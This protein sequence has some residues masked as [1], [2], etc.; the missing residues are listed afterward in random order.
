MN[1]WPTPSDAG[2]NG[3]A[4]WLPAFWHAMTR[5]GEAQILLP[6]FAA[7]VAW[8]VFLSRARPEVGSGSIGRV[9]PVG[10]V[11]RPARQVAWR[12]TLWLIAGTL[13]TT[14][15][16]V[17]FIGY[18]LGSAA[19]DFTGFSG[20][21]M[22]ATAVLPVLAAIVGGRV[23]AA[24]GLVVALTVMVSRVE[25]QVHSWSEVI[26]GALIGLSI[27]AAAL[28]PMLGSRV[29]TRAPWWLPLL[30]AAWLTVLPAR[31][32]PSQT[33]SWVVR[34]SLWISDRPFPY[35]RQQMQWEAQRR[36]A[37]PNARSVPESVSEGGPS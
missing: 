25:V 37:A 15:S 16:K 33:H 3:A 23:G 10:F 20:H 26:G 34:L 8:L 19:L 22:Y 2:A 27:A 6:A 21:T 17:A 30:L 24:C 5:L 4:E 18:G 28:A 36:R 11:G 9:G 1:E 31:A 29:T 14:I 35:T 32:P 13:V 7:G 12:W